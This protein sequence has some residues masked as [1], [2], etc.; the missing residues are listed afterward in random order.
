MSEKLDNDKSLRIISD[1][2]PKASA[3]KTGFYL[4]KEGMTR[5]LL[6]SG[7]WLAVTVATIVPAVILSK[8]GNNKA[9]VLI[10]FGSRLNAPETG[11]VHKALGAVPFEKG[12]IKSIDLYEDLDVNT[13]LSSDSFELGDKIDVVAI[14]KGKGFSGKMKRHNAKG[15]RASHG[16]SLDHRTGGSNGHF[17]NRS[18]TKPG[19]KMAGHLG[20]ERVTTQNLQIVGLV[21]EGSDNMLLINGSVPGPKK[22]IFYI[23]RSS[24]I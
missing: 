7:I 12:D 22:S 9:Q 19:C 3:I 11:N 17:Q 24:R 13:Y 10:N 4:K 8:F 16:A 20:A 6:E 23:R 14:S 5:I 15:G 18:K 1:Q 21:N 2:R